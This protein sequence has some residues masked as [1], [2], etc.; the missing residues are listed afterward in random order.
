MTFKTGLAIA[1][2]AFSAII[3]TA[4]AGFAE[5]LTIKADL[6]ASTEVPP[7]TS[8]A[9]GTLTGTYD[10]AT[11]TVTYNVVYSGL[12][13]P[14]TMAHFHGP[15]PAGKNAPIEVG[16]KGDLASPMKGTATFTGSQAK[17]LADGNMYFNIHTAANKGGEV[18]GQISE[19]K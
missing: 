8:G 9:S 5:T 4:G 2:C 13:G 7:N 17:D 12:T 14:A 15:A 6:K 18:R 1:A 16:I 11:K 3:L 19:A 10:T